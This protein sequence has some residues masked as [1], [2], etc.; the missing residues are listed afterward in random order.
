[1]LR[2]RQLRQRMA[3]SRVNPLVT[4]LTIIRDAS[5]R[6]DIQVQQFQAERSLLVS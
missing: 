2:M 3:S 6:N 4:V 5:M 1:M